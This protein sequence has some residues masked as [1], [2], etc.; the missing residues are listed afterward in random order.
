MKIYI[1]KQRR[2]ELLKNHRP[3]FGSNFIQYD[4]GFINRFIKCYVQK[5]ETEII[6]IKVWGP[7]VTC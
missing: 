5:H 2:Y 6:E 4:L 1:L 3:E 7:R